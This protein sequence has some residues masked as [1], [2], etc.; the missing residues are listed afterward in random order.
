M[1]LREL[2]RLAED[3]VTSKWRNYAKNLISW[4]LLHDSFLFTRWSFVQWWDNCL[5]LMR[6]TWLNQPEDQT[7]LVWC[8]KRGRR[9]SEGH[10]PGLITSHRAAPTSFRT[11][12]YM[13]NLGRF[14]FRVSQRLLHG[15]LVSPDVL[16]EIE[17]CGQVMHIVPSSFNKYSN[18]Y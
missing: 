9:L 13:D 11:V 5:Y 14:C 17:F 7:L 1:W 15:K 10:D 12:C 8:L 6:L 18:T 4:H 3:N 2:R 16:W